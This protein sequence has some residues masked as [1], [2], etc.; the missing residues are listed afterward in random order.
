MIVF[1]RDQERLAAGTA[2]MI[3]D[4]LQAAPKRWAVIDGQLRRDDGF[5]IIAFNRDNTIADPMWIERDCF[6]ADHEVKPP[7][8]AAF[9]LKVQIKRWQRD[10]S[11]IK[12]ALPVA[13]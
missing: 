9:M 5:T 12:A 2:A 6:G 1:Y 10:N 8:L 3:I 4:S 13:A 11:S 7:R